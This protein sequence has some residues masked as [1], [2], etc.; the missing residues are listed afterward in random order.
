MLL[1]LL[2]R[3]YHI[4]V[5]KSAFIEALKYGSQL[6]SSTGMAGNSDVDNAVLGAS[7][8]YFADID[9]A[10]IDVRHCDEDKKVIIWW[11][12]YINLIIFISSGIL[13]FTKL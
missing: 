1:V 8:D 3:Q 5:C 11:I 10:M 4:Y 13:Y 12:L 9:D 7:G 2:A 6:L